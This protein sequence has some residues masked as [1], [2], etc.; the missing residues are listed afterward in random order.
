M[1]HVSPG[2]FAAFV[3]SLLASM[4]AA[5]ATLEIY[6]SETEF[7]AAAPIASTENF[8][9]FQRFTEFDSP[10]VEIDSVRYGLEA[11]VESCTN[12]DDLPTGCWVISFGGPNTI[13]VDGE[14]Q[15]V[16]N[17][18][19]ASSLPNKFLSNNVFDNVLSFGDNAYVEAIG[20]FF[21]TP[22]SSVPEFPLYP[23]DFVGWEILV[24]DLEEVTHVLD[25]LPPVIGD[26]P[27][28]RQYFGFY[29]SL[30]ISEVVVRDKVGDIVGVNWAFDD[31]SRS[32]VVIPL[33]AAIWLLGSAFVLLGFTTRGHAKA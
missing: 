4:P 20:F 1:R 7:L 8:D 10:D 19:P 33:P 31:V 5:S 30:G 22:V 18:W 29:S 21:S 28:E 12:S 25:V 3:L 24:T 6:F 2:T 15:Q 11:G 23:D 17:T 27:S 9:E 14:L 13:F 16:P 26:D 32:A